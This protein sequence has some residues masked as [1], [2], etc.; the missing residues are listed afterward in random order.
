MRWLE[1]TKPRMARGFAPS[2]AF[3]PA[4][5]A[6]AGSHPVSAVIGLGRRRADRLLLMLPKWYPNPPGKGQALRGGS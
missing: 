2:L 4:S 1:I 5:P 3:R 6:M